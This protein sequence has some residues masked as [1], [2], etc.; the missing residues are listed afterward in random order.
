MGRP[1]NVSR[2]EFP[3]RIIEGP[4]ESRYLTWVRNHSNYMAERG[5]LDYMRIV[6]VLVRGI[7]VNFITIL[8]FLMLV[9]LALG[10]IYNP[11][12][13][14]WKSQVEQSAE[15][16]ASG[17][18]TEPRE[19][20]FLTREVLQEHQP[21]SDDDRWRRLGGWA[22]W[23][24]EHLGTKPPFLLLPIVAA[25]AL[26]WALLFPIV[27][28]LFKVIS[29]KKALATGSESS[30]KLRDLYERSFGLSIILIAAVALLEV[31]PLLVHLFN[32]VR[33]NE[34]RGLVVTAAGGS[35]VLAVSAAGKALKLLR[36][37]KHK[38]AMTALGLIGLLLPL[39]VVLHVAE[40]LVY[41]DG[42]Y[43]GGASLLGIP[44]VL[45]VI[46]TL[47][48]VGIVGALGLGWLKDALKSSSWLL[49]WLAA[50]LATVAVLYVI[51][52]WQ[53][54]TGGWYLIAALALEIWLFSFLS[55]DVNLT[56]VH[57]LY[58]DRLA[59]AYLIGVDTKGDVDIEEDI[60]LHEICL[61][62][63][64][65]TAPYHLVNVAHNLQKSKDISIRE[66]NSDFFVF[67][68]RFVGSK[69]T[70]YCRSE[71]LERVFPQMDLATAM[72]ISA[73]AAA[74][75]MGRNTSSIMVALLTLLNVRLGYWIPNPGRLE[76]ELGRQSLR[77][78]GAE[79]EQA[80][81][82][83]TAHET[84]AAAVADRLARQDAADR[85]PARER[86]AH[87]DLGYRF[88][89]VFKEELADIQ[90]RWINRYG[91][92]GDDAEERTRAVRG[93]PS[94]EQPSPDH[95]L[96]GIGFSGGGIRS[97]TINMGIAQALH[98]AGVFDHVD[99]MS[100]VSGGGYLGSSISTLMR[101]REWLFSEIAGEATVD[102]GAGNP[103]I[104]VS[105]EAGER[106]Y[107]FVRPAEPSAAV[108]SG[109]VGQGDPLIRHRQQRGTL[110]ERF[111]WRVRPLALLREMLSS[112]DE[113]RR[114]VNL[115][116]GGHLENLA[117]MELL[118]RRCKYIITGDGE[119]D[120][121][122]QFGS[123]AALIRYARIDLGIEIEIDPGEIRLQSPS[124]QLVREDGEA[125]DARL[126]QVGPRRSANHLALGR[127][128]YPKTDQDEGGFEATFG[129]LIYLKS[130][131]TGDEEEVI[132]Q[133]R[134][135]NPA[136]PH[137]STADQFFDEGQFEA[138]RSLG[139][140]I[141]EQVL[142]FAPDTPAGGSVD[143]FFAD[144]VAALE[145][146]LPTPWSKTEA[147]E[148]QGGST[149]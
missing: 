8:P 146:S 57:G 128:K 9:A 81:R 29:H 51:H 67:S 149:S 7:L 50:P 112:L 141:G 107:R 80:F 54:L 15:S 37:A 84:S 136:F 89:E 118:R 137:E 120:P 102:A 52:R 16:A 66:R 126:P 147:G 143:D 108:A 6:A 64:R 122:L 35:S 53:L 94:S 138:Y 92:D 72:A 40:F 121:Q 13:D 59:S 5:F 49:A 101:S 77:L 135:A 24:Q 3:Y 43:E 46:P 44:W 62:E 103:T 1:I 144:W 134:N 86:I 28:R 26:G 82:P 78:Q 18:G 74:P 148:E 45:L 133:Y 79:R 87:A 10:V 93:R 56:A 85:L 98:R 2:G 36:K 60:D 96:I 83:L 41:D 48:T 69:R 11:M 95:C 68:K 145:Q 111:R 22:W 21:N 20:L 123:L 31:L 32:Q 4:E 76:A 105:G 99:F 117:T 129:Y 73:A 106:T 132:Q 90:Q 113:T 91:G 110:A 127:I 27:I 14:A 30:V 39:L 55:V 23:V 34:L 58:R 71:N 33:T 104:T 139:Q 125:M 119:A 115:S 70:G 88:S 131:F 124:V 12:L 47:L 63:A 97:A 61:Y 17:D 109:I 38:L 130:S 25:L 142:G 19:W 140:H 116:D 75:N 65:S 42:R 100:T 114:W